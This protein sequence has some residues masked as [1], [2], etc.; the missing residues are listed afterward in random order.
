VTDQ[1]RAVAAEGHGGTTAGK[2]ASMSRTSLWAAHGAAPGDTP[3]VAGVF[4]SR[5]VGARGNSVF[6]RGAGHALDEPTLEELEELEEGENRESAGA[7]S[8]PGC[9]LG[10]QCRSGG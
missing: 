8:D 1:R 4:V 6:D 3:V 9:G 5:P 7:T 2:D 10:A